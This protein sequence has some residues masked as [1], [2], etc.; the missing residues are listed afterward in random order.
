MRKPR[1]VLFAASALAI[2]APAAS[3]GR[4]H[5]QHQL[6]VPAAAAQAAHGKGD[7][8][9]QG[10]TTSSYSI[11]L[12]APW[13]DAAYDGSTISVRYTI[14]ASPGVPASAVSDVRTAIGNWNSCLNGSSG[15]GGIVT[16][17]GKWRFVSSASSPLVTITI[18]KGGGVIAGSTK[19]RFDATGFIKGARLQISGSSF[20]RSHTDAIITEIAT[21]ELGHVVG[22][23]HSNDPSDLMYP[24]LN[25]VSAFGSCEVHGVDA[26]YGWLGGAPAQP[27]Q[28]SVSC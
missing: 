12:I 22:L 9:E 16:S 8:H 11:A 24:T 14:S 17:G 2:A 18:K 3:A 15:C 13:G 1:F 20:G 10:A 5:D 26:L 27:S 6:P 23:G 19:L 21:H 4:S 25:R 28:S 7:K